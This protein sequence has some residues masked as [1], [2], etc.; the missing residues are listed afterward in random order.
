MSLN[1]STSIQENAIKNKL[2][3]VVDLLGRKAQETQNALL[4]Y[5]FDDGTVEKRIVIE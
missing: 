5:I 2:I 4:F 3:K 1:T